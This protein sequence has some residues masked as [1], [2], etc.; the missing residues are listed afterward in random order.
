[1]PVSSLKQCAYPGCS[2]LVRG[3]GRCDKHKFVDKRKSDRN[4][5]TAHERGY[6]SEWQKA[7]K[8][9]LK[10]HPLCFYCLKNETVTAASVVDHFVP[11]KL[12]DAKKSGDTKKTQKA[13]KLFWDRANWRSACKPC[14]DRKTGLEKYNQL[15]PGRVKSSGH[16]L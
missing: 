10:E 8:N 16:F 4:R 11:H 7:S 1:M 6:N 2:A 3:S 12:F 5:G 15:I 13:Q 14:H 9:Y